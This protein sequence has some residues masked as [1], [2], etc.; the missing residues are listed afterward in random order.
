M[1]KGKECAEW[2]FAD[3]PEVLSVIRR[4]WAQEPAL[5]VPHSLEEECDLDEVLC[6]LRSI[7]TAAVFCQEQLRLA[8]VAGAASEVQEVEDVMELKKNFYLSKKA[9]QAVVY[10]TLSNDVCASWCATCSGVFLAGGTS[11][12]GCIG[13]SEF[14]GVVAVVAEI[15]CAGVVHPLAVGAFFVEG[16]G[17]DGGDV[18]Q[19]SLPESSGA[20]STVLAVDVGQV[21]KGG[22]RPRN[23]SFDPGPLLAF[24][25][26]RGQDDAL[27][28]FAGTER[29]PSE[30]LF[31]SCLDATCAGSIV[32]AASTAGCCTS[33]G[34]D[35]GAWTWGGNRSDS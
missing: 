6:S 3:D 32:S 31:T 11:W 34:G 30:P 7:R 1:D 28:Y 10:T 22:C 24:P 26:P 15:T 35:V 23:S 5:Q 21:W 8:E 29:A 16:R 18:R 2:F 4:F 17:P 19:D 33:F 12:C 25:F 20:V 27:P 14:A 9:E 13:V